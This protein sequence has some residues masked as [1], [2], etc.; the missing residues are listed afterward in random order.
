[1]VVLLTLGSDLVR[2]LLKVCHDEWVDDL[3]VFVVLGGQ[4]IFHKTDFLSQQINLFFV[5]AHLNLGTLNN[6]L[7]TWV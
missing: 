4:V 5:I 2:K 3:N 1:M 7:K 6:V